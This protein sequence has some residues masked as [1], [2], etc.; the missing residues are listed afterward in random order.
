MNWSHM[1]FKIS[2]GKYTEVVR[3]ERGNL[4]SSEVNMTGREGW[5][6]IKDESCNQGVPFLL[7]CLL[8]YGYSSF[9][10]QEDCLSQF[11]VAI[12]KNISYSSKLNWVRLL[13]PRNQL[14]SF[15]S[16]YII[17]LGWFLPPKRLQSPPIYYS[18]KRL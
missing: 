12:L 8:E 11:D 15:F 18:I 7:A 2:S 3:W 13:F 17:L 9:L 10:L 5:I 16:F 6:C 4:I 14:L 1:C